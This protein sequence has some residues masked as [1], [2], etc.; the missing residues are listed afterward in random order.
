MA[1]EPTP[2]PERVRVLRDGR[3]AVVTIDNPPVNALSQATLDQLA[4]AFAGLDDDEAVRAVVVAGA[5]SR[6]FVA[7]ADIR[8]LAALG[9]GQAALL[10]AAKGQALLDR[11]EGFAKPV[12]AAID[13]A[14]LGGGCEL[15]MACHIR[16][17][18][19]RAVFGLP[20]IN[21]GIM[22]GFG[23]TQRL[24][25]LV[26]RSR[27]LALLLTGDT[28]P[29]DEARALGLADRLTPSG[30]A[31]RSAVEL[32]RTIAAKS[33]PAARLIVEAVREG[34]PLPLAQAQAVEARKFAEACATPDARE[35]LA[36]FLE[37]RQP[38]FT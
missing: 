10:F 6:A 26:G 20:E 1:A 31:L 35:G 11:I 17:A 32:A 9:E 14:C 21:L 22:P 24:P 38:R 37:K 4:R 25:R 8:E 7:G 27:A 3:V 13:G 36:A 2:S 19:A 23:G 15:A 5:G 18:S 29:A 12:I 33:Q 34:L 28:V 16:V 30:E